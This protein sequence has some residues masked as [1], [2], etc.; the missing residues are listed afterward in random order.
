[1]DSSAT[2]E[3]LNFNPFVVNDSLKLIH[4]HERKGSFILFLK[5]KFRICELP[6]GSAT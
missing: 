5:E 3:F 2:F 4:M 6:Y 1:M